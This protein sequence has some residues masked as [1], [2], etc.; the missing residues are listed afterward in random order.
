MAVSSKR[1]RRSDAIQIVFLLSTLLLW[2]PA[3]A[4]IFQPPLSPRRLALSH[5]GGRHEPNSH[6]SRTMLAHPVESNPLLSSVI[7]N[8]KRESDHSSK[9]AHDRHSLDDDMGGRIV[10]EERAFKRTLH[11]GSVAVDNDR[12]EAA[13]GSPRS[14]SSHVGREEPVQSDSSVRL[15]FLVALLASLSVN[16]GKVCQKRGTEDLPLLQM[17]G[18][19]VRS[20]LANPWWLTGFILDVSGALMT[21]V[22]LSLAH[23]SVVQPVLGSGL[24]FVAIFSHYLTSDRMQFMDWVG[25]VICIVGTLGI[26]WT[27]VERDGPEEFYFS[28]A[29]LL[30]LF[31]FSVAAFSELLHRKRLIPQDISSSICAGVCF[32][33]SACSTRTG[34]KI[35]LENGS[36]FAAPFG[37]FLSILLTSTGFVAQT[38]GLKDGRALAVVTYSNLIA[39]L[40]AVIFGILALSEPLPDTIVGLAGRIS[41][42]LLLAFG[43]YILQGRGEHKHRN[44]IEMNMHHGPFANR[45][46]ARDVSLDGSILETVQVLTSIDT[47]QI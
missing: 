4:Q 33:T 7:I 27:S 13:Q 15:G 26:S 23:V 28:I 29:F 8:H 9:N 18:N 34:M 40:V 45:A 19:V 36:T 20:Y 14:N 3:A 47:K 24:A 38:R 46:H 10:A 30:L 5:Q 11:A 37:I 35:A 25:C 41:S 31:F 1:L 21:L 6:P 17:K 16:L 39:L 12:L 44:Q 22:A 42:I 43:S 32:G 2:A